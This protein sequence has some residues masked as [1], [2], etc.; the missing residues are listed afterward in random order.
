MDQSDRSS[1]IQDGTLNVITASRLVPWKRVDRLIRAVP[2]VMREVPNSRFVIVGDGAER[3]ELEALAQSM[4]VA[5]CITFTGSLPRRDV[6]ALMRKSHVFVSTNDLSNVSRGL[7]EAMYLGLCIVTL[8]AGDTCSLVCDGVTGK[9]VTKDDTEALSSALIEVLSQ[10]DERARLGHAASRF[11]R[12][13]EP[14][15][16]AVMR[17]RIAR[18]TDRKSVV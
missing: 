3:S 10:P 5:N 11:I 17:E 1:I 6:F 15:Q 13:H 12:E 18:L 2:A 8:D 9:L 16:E 7:K 4:G 14:S